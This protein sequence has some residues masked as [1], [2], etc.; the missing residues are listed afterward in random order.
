[1]E[2][3]RCDASVEVSQE[4]LS[5]ASSHTAQCESCLFIPELS[6][7]ERWLLACRLLRGL[8]QKASTV[9]A[10][11]SCVLPLTSA[12][13]GFELACLAETKEDLSGCCSAVQHVEITRKRVVLFCIAEPL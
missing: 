9:A 8:P 5:Q 10:R 11:G 1:M 2:N 13:C 7:E 12:A 3:L 4:A 6:P